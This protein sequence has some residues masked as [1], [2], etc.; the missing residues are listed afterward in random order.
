MTSYSKIIFCILSFTILLFSTQVEALIGSTK[1]TGMGAVGQAYPQDAL[2]G[3]FN[4]AGITDICDRVDVGVT[5]IH[6][7]GFSRISGNLVPGVNGRF[8]AYRTK[9]FFSG[10]FG[11]NKRLCVRGW[12][13]A[14]GFVVYNRNANKTTY[15]TE[16][17]LLGTSDL[18]MEYIHETLSPIVAVRYCDHS[19]GISLNYN[20]QRI[21]VDGL[22][23]FDNPFL[24]IEP[25]K[26]TNRGYSYSN[27]I[28]FTVGWKWDIMP[29]LIVGASIQPTCHMNNFGKYKG[30]LAQRGLLKN[31]AI[32]SAGVRYRFLPC[33]SINFDVQYFAWN[34]IRSVHNPLE[35]NIF[36]SR[37]GEENGPGFGWRSQW[38]YRIGA[39]WDIDECW[40]VRAGMRLSDSP[41]TRRQTA[42]NLLTDDTVGNYIMTGFS[43]RPFARSELSFYY[44]HGF[45]REIHGQDSI[46]ETLG[47][48]EV[49]LVQHKDIVSGSIGFYY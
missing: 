44:A 31:P 16:F 46:P 28:G 6:D 49:D 29:C 40:T 18:G 27:G 1:A 3:L 5:W 2:A 41:I 32:V 45:K 43:W 38:I 47:G 14:V 48:G 4:P 30:F 8:G 10:D 22:E 15:S 33:A 7:E 20:I 42:V 35:P 34:K 23:N 26:V 24:S 9:N 21:K 19:F 36:I 13:V 25:G 39:D 12:D 17:P 37:L 11:I